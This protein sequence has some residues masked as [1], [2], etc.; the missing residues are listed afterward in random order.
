MSQRLLAVTHLELNLRFSEDGT[1]VQ[2]Y[3]RAL[4]LDPENDWRA[5]RLDLGG[6]ETGEVDTGQFVVSAMGDVNGDGRPELVYAVTTQR[7]RCHI[8]AYGHEKGTWRASQITKGLPAV[9]LVRSIAVDDLDADGTDEIVVGSRPNGAV[10]VLDREADGYAITTVDRDQYGAGT[11]N[12]REVAIADVDGDGVAEILVATARA[13]AENWH[14]TPGAIYLY[15]RS[16]NGWKRVLID[17]H[18]GRTHTRMVAV[19]DVKNDGVARII[20]SAVG[21]VEPESGRVVGEPELRL[22]TLHG[23]QAVREPIGILENMIKSRSFAAGDID[24]TGR[25]ALVVGTRAPGLAG[26]DKTCLYAYRF[27]DRSGTWEQEALDHSGAFGFHC[28][29]IADVDG[30]G[31][32]EIIAS[33]EER[34]E[35]KLYQREGTGWRKDV[36]YAAE[37]PIFCTALHWLETDV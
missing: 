8:L 10:V 13:G 32:L 34:G 36:I 6:P 25:N 7:G 31:Q 16:A 23:E 37:G 12:T 27:D 2:H 5:Q 14:A 9:D 30:D 29:A 21:V 33:D 22:Y 17:D 4:L 24:G 20:G 3:L 19:A 11:T 28:V 15:K 18:G 35:I 26:R 1:P